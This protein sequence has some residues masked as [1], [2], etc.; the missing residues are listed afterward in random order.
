M[1]NKET[2]IPRKSYWWGRGSHVGDPK[3]CSGAETVQSSSHWTQES[4]VVG[5]QLAFSQPP[6]FSFASVMGASDPLAESGLGILLLSMQASASVSGLTVSCFLV[7]LLKKEKL[8]GP[9]L[10]VWAESFKPALIGHRTV[11]ARKRG[12]APVI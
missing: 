10:P 6:S 9:A 11:V 2:R 3:G 12:V 8:I 4:L 5:I 1:V 7:Q